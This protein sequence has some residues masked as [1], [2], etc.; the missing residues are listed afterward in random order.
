M[1]H[2]LNE[3]RYVVNVMTTI[4]TRG[5]GRFLFG[6]AFF[7]RLRLNMKFLAGQGIVYLIYD[8]THKMIH[9]NIYIVNSCF[10]CSCTCIFC[11]ATAIQYQKQTDNDF[12]HGLFK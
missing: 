2:Q 12:T 6:M 4:N 11:C 5:G 8:S 7:K 1:S 10:M 3:I 9:H